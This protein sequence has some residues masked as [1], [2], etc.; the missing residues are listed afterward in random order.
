M[1]LDLGAVWCHWCHVMEEDTYSDPK[2]LELLR[3][4]YLTVRVD[5]DS[6][7]DLSNRYEDY[8][9]PATIVFAADGSEIVKRRGF[10]P[11]GEMASMLQAIIDDPSPGPSVTPE[12][13]VTASREASLAAALREE[14]Q[15]NFLEGY[16]EK[17]GSWGTVQKFLDWDNV[18]R[19][20][21]LAR[22]GDERAL[23][24]ATQTLEA[25]RALIDPI[26]GGVYQ[27][28]TDGDWK[29]PHFEKIIQM[30]A[31]NLR[32][33]ALAYAQLGREADL[34]S[35]RLIQRYLRDFLTSP[36]GAFYT[37]QDADLVPGEHA[38][39]YF[40]LDDKARRKQGIPRIDKNIYARENGWAINALVELSAATVDAAALK[41]AV[42][43]AEW[44]CAQR[45]LPGGGFRHGE[46]GPGYLGDTLGM[47]RAFLRLYA[48][49]AERKWLDRASAACAYI[50]ANFKAEAGFPSAQVDPMAIVKARPQFEENAL[51]ARFANLLSRY[52]GNAAQRGVAEHALKYL[53]APEVAATRRSAV[54]GVLSADAELA[55]APL[56]IV[57]VGAKTDPAARALFAVA[58]RYPVVYRQLE[59]LDRGE[60]DAPKID[61]QFPE[62]KE[63]AA[64]VCS[65]TACSPPISDARQFSER[66]DKFTKRK[67]EP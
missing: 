7:P 40:A 24:M 45:A 59:W 53:A 64:Y 37:S 62:L 30:Q 14:L 6:R 49:T 57:V 56:H 31:E 34:A 32:V 36:E 28:S 66:V 10:I 67:K 2:V 3:A 51:L 18:E 47:G 9:W 21:T 48:V 25:Q 35:A 13:P 17:E 23:R 33:Y 44:I 27:Y 22:G 5:Q 54:G 38:G 41:D 60:K 55:V 39:E 8:G 19:C 42:R 29:H 26:W 50:A 46:S 63:A 58:S 11:P 12:K 20:L 16:D 52:T 15:K 61:V 43:A 4:R 65:A 1:L